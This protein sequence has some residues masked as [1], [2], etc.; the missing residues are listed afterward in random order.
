MRHRVPTRRVRGCFENR[1]RAT[2]VGIG[3]GIEA[4][5][6]SI[7]IPTPDVFMC[8]RV[9]HEAREGLFRK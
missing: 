4:R 9:R 3:I 1:T 2:N 6:S 8:H 5:I 7:P